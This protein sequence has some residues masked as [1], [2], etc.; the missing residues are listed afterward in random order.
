MTDSIIIVCGPAHRITDSRRHRAR[1]YTIR[2]REFDHKIK[3]KKRYHLPVTDT[4]GEFQGRRSPVR[5]TNV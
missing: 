1:H 2:V 5:I 4:E 3:K